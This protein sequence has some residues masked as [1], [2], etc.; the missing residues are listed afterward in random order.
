MMQVQIHGS[1]WHLAE[2]RGFQA[3]CGNDPPRVTG[4]WPNRAPMT[5][6]YHPTL[7]CAAC[8]VAFGGTE[9][10]T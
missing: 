7:R 2:S 4:R 1:A 3:L 10:A 8:W 9:W 6:E 5:M